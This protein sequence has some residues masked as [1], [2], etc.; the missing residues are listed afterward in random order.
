M[1]NNWK[2]AT[3]ILGIFV[4]GLFVM[5]IASNPKMMEIKTMEGESVMFSEDLIEKAVEINKD[6]DY[7]YTCNIPESKCV[8][9]NRIKHSE[10]N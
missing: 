1:R 10:I 8:L 5:V 2:I 9:F 3:V 7:F 4:L 6:N